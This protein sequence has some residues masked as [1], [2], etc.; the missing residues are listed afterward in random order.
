MLH[1]IDVVV[2]AV[3]GVAAAAAATAVV[4]V[5]VVDTIQLPLHFLATIRTN[6]YSTH[7]AEMDSQRSSRQV[8][9]RA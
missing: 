2:G 6:V 8:S 7:C 3:V 1:A 9:F 4:V 5:A